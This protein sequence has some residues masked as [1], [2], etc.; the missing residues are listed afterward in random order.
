MPFCLNHPVNET[1]KC[2]IRISKIEN[3]SEVVKTGS[4]WRHFIIYFVVSV[5][6]QQATL[7]D[8]I[9]Y[10]A[11]LNAFS[12]LIA[13]N[14]S[15]IKYKTFNIWKKNTFFWIFFNIRE[16]SK[17]FSNGGLNQDRRRSILI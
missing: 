15:K 2:D 13:S 14:A 4:A 9:W 12:G 6:V 17:D 16:T 11:L 10:I 7:C 5:F 1:L 8:N 3:D